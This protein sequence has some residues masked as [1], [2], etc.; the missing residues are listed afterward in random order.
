MSL[1]QQ[2]ARVLIKLNLFYILNVTLV[3]ISRESYTIQN[4][5]RMADFQ[6]TVSVMR[7]R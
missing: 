5:A 3:E 6:R 7:L 2:T 1:N 4:M